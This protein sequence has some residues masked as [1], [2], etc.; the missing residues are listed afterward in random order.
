L[1]EGLTLYTYVGY[2]F[3]IWTVAR[4]RPKPVMKGCLFPTVS[5]IIAAYN[6]ERVIEDKLENTMSLSYPKDKLEI[7]L[8]ADGSVDNTV[9]IAE[10]FRSKGI[11]VLYE[12]QR[13]GK[14]A[15]INRA[16]EASKGEILLF[17]DS[18]TVY[19]EGVIEALM[20]NFHDPTV[21]GVSGRKI[22]L[23]DA[24]RVANQGETAFWSYESSL[25]NW[26][27][28]AGSIVTADGEIFSVRRSLFEPI[29]PNVVHD[30]M[31]LT[32]AIIK[33]GYRVVYENDATSGE[34]ASKHLLDE[35]H[36]KVRY[37]SAGYQ[38]VSFFRA[39]LIPP[40]TLFA[41]EFLSHKL[42]RWLA[43][44]FIV[45]VFASSA[46]LS[47]PFYRFVFWIQVLF[48]V[49]AAIGWRTI[50]SSNSGML[51]FPVYFCMGNLAAAYGLVR[52]FSSGQS[53]LWRKAE[54]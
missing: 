19:S 46:L 35:F 14:T 43:P 54:R 16:V 15:A 9:A 2:P 30:D 32:L 34:H 21:G 29:P 27:S 44:V 45:M 51:Y 10:T 42:C 52:Y 13:R 6:E 39:M 22:I 17:S 3:G 49:L 11:R 7:I 25:K 26:E 8:V 48:L 37:A 1:S 47:A 12:P 40:R 20:K 18:N 33:K 53:T 28:L 5:L 24:M 31:Y 50:G 4:L 38:I 23:Q 36:L 41:F